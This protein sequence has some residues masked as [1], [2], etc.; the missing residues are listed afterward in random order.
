MASCRAFGLVLIPVAL[1]LSALVPSA[2][3]D[4]NS[5]NDNLGPREIS[6]GE[7]QR[8]DARGALAITLNPA[9][10]VLSRALVFEASYGHRAGDGANAIAVSACDS[11]NVAPGCFYYRYFKAVP[12]IGATSFSRRVH[13]VGAVMSKRLSPNVSLGVT[14]RYF[15]YNSDLMGEGEG[16]ASG[17]SFDIGT[18]ITLQSFNLALVGYNLWGDDSAQ[19]PMAIGTGFS[20][21]PSPQLGIS[22]DAVWNLDA[23]AGQSAGRY[24]GGAEYFFQGKN[25]QN[26]YPLRAGV[27]YDAGL[28]GTYLT[29]GVG[30]L[31]RKMGFDVGLRK[32]VAGGDELM[33][34]ASLRIFGP[35][36]PPRQQ[37]RGRRRF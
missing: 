36:M 3:A 13:E 6:L 20:V 30:F 16:A 12:E 2:R 10:L 24:G 37:R 8:A 34:Q 32:Q 27:V 23:P 33:I 15:D 28:K 35:R 18:I 17:F 11:T 19:Y 14:S 26:G 1:V 22:V 9:G 25:R 31:S 7:A 21:R 4:A 5:L 29:A